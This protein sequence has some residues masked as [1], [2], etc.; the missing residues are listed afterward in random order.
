VITILSP[1]VKLVVEVAEGALDAP[2]VRKERECAPSS[3]PVNT[4][5]S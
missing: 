3:P 4:R 2:T 1:A 5:P